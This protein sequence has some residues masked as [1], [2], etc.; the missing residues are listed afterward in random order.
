[1]IAFTEF[2]W[3]K[4]KIN[5]QK[6]PT[7]PSIS[8]AIFRSQYQKHDNIPKITGATYNFI[9]Q[10]YYG[11]FV[12]TYKVKADDVYSSDVN[13]LYPSVMKTKDMPIGRHYHFWGDRPVGLTDK[14]F[15]GF[16]KVKVTAPNMDKPILPFKHPSRGV[17][18]PQGT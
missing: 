12:D 17:I 10:A 18:Y 7:L 5:V 14:E 6:Y 9:K 2:I 3:N 1:M 4:F 11:G 16:V 13:S 15:F 8:F